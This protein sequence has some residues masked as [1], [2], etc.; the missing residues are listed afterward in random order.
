ELYYRHLYSKLARQLTIVQRFGS[1]RNYSNFF[2]TLLGP[3][4]THVEYDL[5]YCVIGKEP[6]DATIH[7]SWIWDIIDEFIYQ[8]EEFS[9]YRSRRNELHKEEIELLK[10]NPQVFSQY[11]NSL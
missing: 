3:S 11:S 6:L 1:W 5:Y 2:E 9:Q 4:I 10:E 7:V 8:Y